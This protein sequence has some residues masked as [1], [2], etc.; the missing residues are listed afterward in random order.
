MLFGKSIVPIAP[1]VGL[2][3]YPADVKNWPGWPGSSDQKA[4]FWTDG[5]WAPI[6]KSATALKP[7][8]NAALWRVKVI[9]LSSV[10]FLSPDAAGNR[11][12]RRTGIYGPTRD[13]IAQ[14]LALA[15]AALQA[16][17][18]G[19]LAVAYDT[20]EDPALYEE[21]VEEGAGLGE[22]AL[23]AYVSP[24]INGG[25]FEANDKLYHGPYNVCLVIHA[26]LSKSASCEASGTPVF[27]IS[28]P[29]D[30]ATVYAYADEVC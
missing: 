20:T 24:R 2:S 11:V 5:N 25:A 21:T 3:D 16:Q 30:D 7:E 6:L 9:L 15:G 14:G 27:G 12:E 29:A 1:P 23:Q 22:N 28:A 8:A 17:T 18:G 13:R 26:G 19:R 10:D 4:L